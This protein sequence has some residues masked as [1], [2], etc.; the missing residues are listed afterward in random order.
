[1]SN[2]EL[3]AETNSSRTVEVLRE[4]SLSEVV[5]FLAAARTEAE[6][7]GVETETGAEIAFCQ[8]DPVGIASQYTDFNIRSRHFR[9]VETFFVERD[10]AGRMTGLLTTSGM[11]RDSR[12]L[13]MFFVAI[14]REPGDDFVERLRHLLQGVCDRTRLFAPAIAKLRLTFVLDPSLGGPLGSYVSPALVDDYERAGMVEEAR[15]ANETAPG[16]EAVLLTYYTMRPAGHVSTGDGATNGVPNG[17][18]AAGTGTS[19]DGVS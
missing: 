6:G 4:N 10:A 13:H 18:T 7:D 16:R 15:I 12:V 9:V 8:T 11:R 19:G 1:M 2:G 14:R 17:P 3:Q 5:A